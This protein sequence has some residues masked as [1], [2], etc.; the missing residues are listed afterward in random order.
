[1]YRLKPAKEIRIFC[2]EAFQF[3]ITQ[4]QVILTVRN[5]GAEAGYFLSGTKHDRVPS[6]A[7]PRATTHSRV[8][9]A[10]NGAFFR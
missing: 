1:M 2:P 10:E 5:N 4:S 8:S 7:Q 9:R 6:R 3:V